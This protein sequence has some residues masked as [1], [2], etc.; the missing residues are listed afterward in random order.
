[1]VGQLGQM[2]FEVARVR[3]LERGTNAAV[4]LHTA[5][6]GE[7]VV[8]GVPDQHVREAHP[9][10][11]ARHVRDDPL[12]GSF[13]EN[14]EELLTA[15]LAHSFERDEV[16]LPPEHRGEN[17]DEPAVVR[18]VSQPAAD[19]RPHAFRDH[20]PPGFGVG[21]RFERLFGRQQPH[22]LSDEE[23]VAFGRA[24]NGADEVCRR[25]AV[26]G[27]RDESPYVGLG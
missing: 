3:L 16:E 2:R 21:D 4:Q 22:H 1:V 7:L 6:G 13:V 23:G 14:L 12:P 19:H 25:L 18:Q 27:K 9:T 24:M 8:Q 15:H 5:T 17:K 26:G 11:L 10:G 20:P